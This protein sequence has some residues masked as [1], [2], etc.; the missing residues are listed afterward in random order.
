MNLLERIKFIAEQN[1]ISISYIEKTLGFANKSIYRWNT[2]MPSADKVLAVAKL[3]KVSIDWLLTG[4]EDTSASLPNDFIKKYQQLSAE[5]KL[6]ISGFIDIALLNTNTITEDN[7]SSSYTSSSH[8]KKIQKH[9]IEETYD[10][11]NELIREK[12]PYRIKEKKI[13]N[14]EYYKPV[15]APN[16]I[17]NIPYIGTV[18]AGIPNLSYYDGAYEYIGSPVSC[19]FAMRANGD[20]MYPVIDNND[21]IYVKSIPFLENG[22]IGI[23]SINGETTC[24]KFYANNKKIILKA[25]NSDYKDMEYV[26]NEENDIRIMGRVILTPEQE[27]RLH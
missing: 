13:Y 21:Y 9:T 8:S 23:I 18:A 2:N 20:S 25:I 22:E 24:K 17:E 7:D 1:N 6:K 15:D 27:K 3:L 11:S 16:N 12:S 4:E 19:D 5:N 10:P 26:L 14:Y